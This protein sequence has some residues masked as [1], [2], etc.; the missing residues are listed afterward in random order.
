[1]QC[2]LELHAIGLGLTFGPVLN[3]MGRLQIMPKVR[4]SI[5]KPVRRCYPIIIH[6]L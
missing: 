2:S 6:H 3:I 1:V 4:S 5:L